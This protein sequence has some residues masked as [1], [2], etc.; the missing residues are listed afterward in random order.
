MGVFIFPRKTNNHDHFI[1]HD[2][3]TRGAIAI[4]CERE[5]YQVSVL[6]IIVPDV[7]IAFARIAQLHRRKHTCPVIALTGSNGKTT[8]K[9]MI[10]S[11][12]PQHSLATPGNFNNHFG[13]PQ[14]V[15]TL[16]QKHRYAVFELGANHPQEIAHTAAIVE[17]QVALIN[18][19]APAHMEGFGS[20]D[21]IARAKGELYEQLAPGMTAIV[22]EDDQY[23]HF[24][25]PILANK[26][27][28]RFSR[29]TQMDVYA[30]E[31]QF[32][33]QACAQF[34]LVLPHAE[35][36][37]HLNVPGEHMISNALAAAACAHAV[38]ISMDEIVAGLNCFQGVFGRLTFIP[39][40]KQAVVINDTYNANLRSVLVALEVLR[41]RKGVR[42]FVFGDMG[43]LGHWTGAHHEQVG[44]ASRQYG[45]E[46]LMT[47][48]QHSAVA[49]EAFGNGAIHYESKSALIA[50]LLADMNA[51]T[52]VL[53]KGSRA[54]HM[55]EV[56]Y[57]I[58]ATS[59]YISF[60][61][62]DAYF[63]ST[64]SLI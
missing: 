49:T 54:A 46:R 56:V 42:I 41:A 59:A 34:K 6:Q 39:G 19:I 18:N 2:A 5:V 45:I 48:G 58:I 20:L 47:Y 23:A 1:I 33:A 32:D 35:A 28:L 64:S 53:V 8:T 13:V 14:T 38:D 60:L 51:H 4:L 43:E 10:A 36:Y 24:W 57:A 31:I 44:L 61:G 55:E 25:D 50:A 9:D 21:G 15:L 62:L 26:N 37:I 17:P 27:V 11:I 52:T 30:S 7:V 22:N 16:E 3:V 40:Q 12:L 63:Q 29:K